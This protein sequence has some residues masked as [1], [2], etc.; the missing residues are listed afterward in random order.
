MKIVPDDFPLT[1]MGNLIYGRMQSSPLLT[2]AD[3]QIAS[4]TV[5]LMNEAYS[6][7]LA[8]MQDGCWI[9]PDRRGL[10]GVSVL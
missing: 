8:M 9:G 5:A 3:D 1:A 6:N 7:R 2:A 4:I 10:T